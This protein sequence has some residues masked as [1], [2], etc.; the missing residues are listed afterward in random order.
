MTCQSP[1]PPNTA[2]TCSTMKQY[3][4]GQGSRLPEGCELRNPEP[5][6]GFDSDQ[7]RRLRSR[8][9]S[10]LG[11]TRE[12]LWREMYLIVVPDTPSPR[13]VAAEHR[14]MLQTLGMVLMAPSNRRGGNFRF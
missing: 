11:D 4:L 2:P 12:D 14:V 5:L 9:K 3:H 10:A 6:E 8:K 13:R 1:V 7:E